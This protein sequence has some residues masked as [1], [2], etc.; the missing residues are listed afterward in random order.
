MNK[1][2]LERPVVFFERQWPWAVLGGS[3]ALILTLLS[4][5]FATGFMSSVNDLR[6]GPNLR[7]YTATGILMG[8]LS[9]FFVILTMWYSARKR[10]NVTGATMM[11]WLW[12]HVYFGL[13][14]VL[15]AVLHAGSG[16]LSASLTSGK[17]LFLLFSVIA[18]SGIFWRLA[19]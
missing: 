11:T 14:A 8:L 17:L 15:A 6:F 18:G 2:R 3:I 7:G 9:L 19:T 13:L 10:R 4:L 16:L 5:V 1:P 12:A